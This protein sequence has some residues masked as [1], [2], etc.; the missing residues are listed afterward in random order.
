MYSTSPGYSCS[1]STNCSMGRHMLLAITSWNA[2]TRRDETIISQK[3]QT[4][5]TPSTLLGDTEYP[6]RLGPDAVTLR[7]SSEG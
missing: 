5:F 3:L 4:I 2:I 7:T 6:S 1:T